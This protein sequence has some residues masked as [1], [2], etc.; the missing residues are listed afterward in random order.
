MTWTTNSEFK[1]AH[2]ELKKQLIENCE[3]FKQYKVTTL[4]NKQNE[5][6]VKTEIKNT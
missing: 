1:D 6:I 4:S 2:I 3:L 5:P